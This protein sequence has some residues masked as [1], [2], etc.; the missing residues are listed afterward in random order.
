MFTQI[1]GSSTRIQKFGRAGVILRARSGETLSNEQ[2]SG[3]C[4]SVFAERKHDSRSSRY[5]Y[6]PT[7]QLLNGMRDAGFLPVE[8]R[9]GGSSDETRRGFTKHLIRFRRPGVVQNVGDSVPELIML[10]SHDGTS[11]YQFMSGWFRLVCSNGLVVADTN[12]EIN[13]IRVGH[14]GNILDDVIE[15]SYRVIDETEE[16]GRLIEDMTRIELS[17]EEQTAFALAARSLRFDDDSQVVPAQII[18]AR[19]SED[20]GNSLWLTLNRAQENLINGGITYRSVNAN[21]HATRRHAREI[22]GIDGNIRLNRALWTL[23]EEMR[24]IKAN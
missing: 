15:A 11:S 12:K 3:A 4:P 16:Q 5:T 14:R 23:A 9:Q 6:L 24:R 18:R 10:N 21:G 8:V 20:V 7:A 17:H 22:N 19:R 2:I 1:N 13:G